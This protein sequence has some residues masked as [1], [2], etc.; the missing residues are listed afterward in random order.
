MIGYHSPAGSSANPLAHTLS[1]SDSYIKIN[2]IYASEFMIHTYTA[3]LVKV[4]VVFLSG[5]ADPFRVK[6]Y[7]GWHRA[8]IEYI[9]FTISNKI[10]NTMFGWLC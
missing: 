7:P 1:G 4:P 2:E 8:P 6:R 10:S 3:A 9:Q 5:D